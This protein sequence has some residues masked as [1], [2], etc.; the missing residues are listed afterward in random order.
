[1]T[2]HLVGSPLC[3]LPAGDITKYE[4]TSK[5]G[6]AETPLRA[7][8]PLADGTLTDSALQPLCPDCDAPM[9]SDICPCG[10]DASAYS[11]TPKGDREPGTKGP[12][13][14]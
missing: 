7:G 12:S 5:P 11:Q 3:G 2:P 4:D 6:G 10:Y 13:A 9:T 1:M 8:P 14:S